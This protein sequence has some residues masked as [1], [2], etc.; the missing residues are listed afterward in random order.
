ME[1]QI[2]QMENDRLKMEE[3][4]RNMEEERKKMIRGIKSVKSILENNTEVSMEICQTKEDNSNMDA[5]S[6]LKKVK[7]I[8]EENFTCSICYELFVYPTVI[9][10]GHCFCHDCL[11][12]CNYRCPI[13]RKRF[14]GNEM[15][16]SISLTNYLRD[17]IDQFY[18][19]GYKKSRSNLMKMRR[20]RHIKWNE[21][22]KELLG[23]G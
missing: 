2:C 22:L 15:H 6:S 16:V 19:E 23:I 3:N 21:Y 1:E 18:T 8:V 5:M 14:L 7:D 13:C 11:T 10:C 12:R 17:I 20:H 9:E 4:V